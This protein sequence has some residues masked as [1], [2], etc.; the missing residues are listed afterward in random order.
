MDKIWNPQGPF[1]KSPETFRT[2]FGCHNS[3]LYLR[4]AKVLSHQT[5][6]YSLFFL[7]FIENM[8]KDQLFKSSGLQFDNWL[9]G[10]EKLSG[11]SINRPQI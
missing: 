5:S 1:L 8:L 6:Q 11:L 7:F 3:P 2:F 4:N 10:P 9:Y